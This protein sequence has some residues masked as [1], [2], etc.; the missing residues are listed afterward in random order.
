[1]ISN[2]LQHS[3]QCFMHCQSSLE[4]S[5]DG[6]VIMNSDA[7][8]LVLT[9]VTILS[10]P[11]TVADFLVSSFL[12]RH[13]RPGGRILSPCFDMRSMVPTAKAKSNT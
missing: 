10:R 3:I 13:R 5:L 8:C 6:W 12:C 4:C 2:L 7:H 9:F 1:M 11:F